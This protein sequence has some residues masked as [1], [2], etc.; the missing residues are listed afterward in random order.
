MST[1]SSISIRTED[2]KIKTI[3]CHW[4]G[5][6]EHNGRLLQKYYNIQYKVKALIELGDLSFLDKHSSQP[7]GHSFKHPIKGHTV[8]YG[9]DRGEQG[10]EYRTYQDF[11][12]AMEHDHREY[13]YIWDN[14]WLVLHNN[15]IKKL[16]NVI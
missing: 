13:N 5:Y 3:Y 2:D 9:R 14:E 1:N 4:D 12:Q 6:I 11:K 15:M 10:T 16:K 7:E 8:A